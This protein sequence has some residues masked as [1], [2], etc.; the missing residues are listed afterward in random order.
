Y[1]EWRGIHKPFDWARHILEVVA[2]EGIVQASHIATID[3]A[4]LDALISSF[5]SHAV[6]TARILASMPDGPVLCSQVIQVK[7]PEEIDPKSFET[8]V[9]DYPYRVNCLTLPEALEGLKERLAGFEDHF[10]IRGFDYRE[11]KLSTVL[12]EILACSHPAGKQRV[13]M[14]LIAPYYLVKRD[15]IKSE[16]FPPDP[17]LDGVRIFANNFAVQGLKIKKSK[18]LLNHIYSIL[19]RLEAPHLDACPF[20]AKQDGIHVMDLS[21]IPEKYR[22]DV[23]RAEKILNR[24]LTH[25]LDALRRYPGGGM[26]GIRQSET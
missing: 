12:R 11:E 10:S 21:F 17:S 15:G 3:D 9:R 8:L 6:E 7:T 18:A 16:D 25:W 1:D 24:A 19:N 2:V 20:L 26:A 14:A 5:E 22:L 13:R 4:E 23:H